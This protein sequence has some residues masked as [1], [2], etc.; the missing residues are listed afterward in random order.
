MILVTLALRAVLECKLG[1]S[2]RRARRTSTGCKRQQS[3]C[4]PRGITAEHV[5]RGLA[6]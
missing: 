1:E 4:R 3:A 6:I 2:S 5:L